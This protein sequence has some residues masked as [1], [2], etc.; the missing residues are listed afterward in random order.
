MYSGMNFEVFGTAKS[1]SAASNLAYSSKKAVRDAS[2][3]AAIGAEL[4]GADRL[5]G[6]DRSRRHALSR[7]SLSIAKHRIG[8]GARLRK[9]SSS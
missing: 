7:L 8:T 5:I 2:A 3:G 1:F 4:L 6:S 9:L